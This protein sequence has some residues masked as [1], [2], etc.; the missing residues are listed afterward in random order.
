MKNKKNGFL[1]LHRTTSWCFTSQFMRVL[2]LTTLTISG[3]LVTANLL[4]SREFKNDKPQLTPNTLQD[5]FK[6]I[7]REK[8]ENAVLSACRWMTSVAQVKTQKPD[9]QECKVIYKYE[10]WKGAFKGEYSP[11]DKWK[12][13]GTI[14]HTGQGVKA[15]SLAYKYFKEPYM[16]E[17]ARSAA[18][19][20]LNQQETDRNNANYGMVLGFEDKAEGIN[21][22]CILECCDGLFTLSEITGEKRYSDRAID[23]INWVIKRLY[24]GHGFFTDMYYPYKKESQKKA[25]PNKYG[26]PGRP[27]IEDGVLLKAWKYTGD[28]KYR[29]IF[30]E[31]AE[32]LLEREEPI[33]NWV[34]YTPCNWETG[35]LHP[36]MAFWWGRPMCMAYKDSSN[37]N[38]L[39]CFNNAC[40]WYTK[41][42]RYDGGIFRGTYIDFNTNSFGHATSA[43]SCAVMMF[44]DAYTELGE[45]AYLP[46][47]IK[48]LSFALSMQVTDKYRDSNLKGVVIEKFMAPQ[49]QDFS[50]IYIRDIGTTFFIT[51]VTQILL[52]TKQ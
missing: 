14:W 45:T 25:F 32:K 18:E 26:D 49:G 40:Q 44:R 22:S 37:K 1:K 8:L 12:F 52:D 24:V 28:K 39:E 38:Y 29:D 10:N 3:L 9:T 36:R 34:T 17:S 2:R 20:I 42:M 13:F 6:E 46:F 27:L 50:P 51:A 19:F 43:V 31:V 47:L 16:L 30:Y 23:A 5:I 41:A 7:P 4:F 33:G 21:A 35:S 48:G 15:L 11:G